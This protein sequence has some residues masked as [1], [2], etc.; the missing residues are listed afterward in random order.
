MFGKWRQIGLV[1]AG[2]LV[3]VMISINYSAVAQRSM[4]PLPVEARTLKAVPPMSSIVR[5][6][7]G[8]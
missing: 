8:V 2:I 6:C 1:T 5:L 4:T 3:G 7:P